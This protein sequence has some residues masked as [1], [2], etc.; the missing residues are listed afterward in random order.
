MTL[1]DHLHRLFDHMYWAD[2]L[3]LQ[4]LRSAPEPAAVRLFA[5]VLG[6][7]RVWLTRLRGEDSQ[8]LEV[9]PSLDVARCE[10]LAPSNREGFEEYLAGLSPE[11]LPRGI[12]YR[13]QQGA[14]FR[15]AR[16]DIL[17]HVATHGTYHRGQIA[18]SL[19]AAGHE[20]VNTDFIVWARNV[21]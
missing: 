9:W 17:S 2:D 16:I 19:R 14:P 10:E 4:R 3:V 8:G 15:A 20:P 6:A 21:G 18:Q 11:A 5:H 7:E 13:N 12:E 1:L